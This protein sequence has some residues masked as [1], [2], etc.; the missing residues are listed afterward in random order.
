MLIN[1]YQSRRQWQL[2]PT[3]NT[4]PVV[5]VWWKITDGKRQ[6][7]VKTAKVFVEIFVEEQHRKLSEQ[8]KTFT[9]SLKGYGAVVSRKD[10]TL[11]KLNKKI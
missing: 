3:D 8:E 2:L 10:L 6:D 9:S 5:V 7:E 11:E 4:T 1:Q